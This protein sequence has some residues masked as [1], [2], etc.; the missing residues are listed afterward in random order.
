MYNIAI[1]LNEIDAVD[2]YCLIPSYH[3]LDEKAQ[4]EFRLIKT[5][6]ETDNFALK[7]LSVFRSLG[8][9][10]PDVIIQHGLTTESCILAAYCRLAGIK[11]IFMFAHDVEA[12]GLSQTTQNKV[13][14]FK[15]L[16]DCSH[17]LISQ[18]NYQERVLR[19]RYGARSIVVHNGFVIP[20]RRQGGESILWVARC[21]TWKNPELFIEIANRHPAE[22]FV[23]VCP[24]AG[25]DELF[26]KVRSRADAVE[27]LQFHDFIPRDQIDSFFQSAKLF[28]NTSKFE[29]F[30]QTFIQAAMNSTPIITLNVN[31]GGFLDDHGCG[32]CS[33]GDFDLL[34]ATLSSLLG[35]SDT[36]SRMSENAYC[37]AL[38]NH[39]IRD[40]VE[41]L[42]ELATE[43]KHCTHGSCTS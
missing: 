24:R 26:A 36:L 39:D 25:D 35:D 43:P 12:K 16:L 11:F 7:A 41:R 32:S 3:S 8:R 31:P 19:T 5:Y 21:E 14:L 37:Y 15:L 4:N 23:M 22:S 28:L 1:G 2:T 30:P 18:N 17:C 9:I 42:L 38:E 40:T 27:N 29:G 6:K 20:E 10:A 13:K 34:D 33:G